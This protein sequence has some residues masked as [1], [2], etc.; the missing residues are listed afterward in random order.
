[1]ADLLYSGHPFE[2]KTPEPFFLVKNTDLQVLSRIGK[3]MIKLQWIPDTIM[4]ISILENFD[5]VYMSDG[6]KIA[7]SWIGKQLIAFFRTDQRC[8]QSSL[9]IHDDLNS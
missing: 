2:S 9:D 4:D 6:V 7:L 5:N 3:T 8:N 1:M